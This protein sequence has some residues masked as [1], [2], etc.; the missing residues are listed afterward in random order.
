[1]VVT[2]GGG[3]VVAS[4]NGTQHTTTGAT[5]SYTWARMFHASAKCM[6]SKISFVEKEA[7]T[8]LNK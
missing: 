8:E 6:T 5:G 7:N 3:G 2:D 4:A 1:M